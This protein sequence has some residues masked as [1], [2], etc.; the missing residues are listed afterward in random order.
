MLFNVINSSTVCNGKNCFRGVTGRSLLYQLKRKVPSYYA[1]TI[2]QMVD[3]DCK[4]TFVSNGNGKVIFSIISVWD[5]HNGCCIKLRP[6][7]KSGKYL[8]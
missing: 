4:P 2:L 5:G 6:L 3:S 7:K 8:V 1:Y